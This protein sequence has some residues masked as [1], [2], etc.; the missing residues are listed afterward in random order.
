MS[1]KQK[2]IGWSAPVW[3][4]D[5]GSSDVELEK[6]KLICLA[7]MSLNLNYSFGLDCFEEGYMA[8][9]FY[10]N[11]TLVGSIQVVEEEK[12]GIF[13]EDSREIYIPFNDHEI[14]LVELKI[15]FE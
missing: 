3:H 12:F 7:V 6:L 14:N 8:V 15:I 4:E 11:E 5:F 13:F 2:I 9:N 10:K 1:E